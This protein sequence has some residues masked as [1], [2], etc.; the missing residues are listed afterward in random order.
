MF[1][2]FVFPVT[3]EEEAKDFPNGP[4]PSVVELGGP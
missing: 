1:L 4:F 3:R 2:L